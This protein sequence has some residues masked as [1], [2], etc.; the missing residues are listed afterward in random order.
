MG[1]AVDGLDPPPP[2]PQLH[3]SQKA[4]KMT[5]NL[6]ISAYPFSPNWF[7]I[8]TDLQYYIQYDFLVNCGF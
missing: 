5:A 6:F 1:S 4:D 3:V 8:I 7:G 2:P